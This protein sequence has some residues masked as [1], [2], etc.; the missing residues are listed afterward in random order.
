[1][2]HRGGVLQGRVSA[3]A[4]EVINRELEARMPFGYAADILEGVGGK[5]RNRD[6]C[7]FRGCPQPVQRSVGDPSANGI[8]QARVT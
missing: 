4:P 1:M 8:A 6:V 7:C 5:Q 2:G 3:T